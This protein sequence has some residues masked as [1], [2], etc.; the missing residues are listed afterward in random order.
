MDPK[1]TV[2]C[3]DGCRKGTEIWGCNP[4][5]DESSKCKAAI[6]MGQISDA[7]GRLVSFQLV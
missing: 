5:I 2:E 7:A 6:G 4:F 1:Y 3:P